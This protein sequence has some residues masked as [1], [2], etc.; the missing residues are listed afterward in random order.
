[1]S[2]ALGNLLQYLE[3]TRPTNTANLSGIAMNSRERVRAALQHRRPDAIPIDFGAT[4]VTGIHVSCVA[5]LRDHYGLHRHPVKVHEPYQM[6]GLIEDDLREAM[7]IDTVGITPRTTMFGF[8]NTA[9]REFRLPWGQEVLV[10]DRFV[11]RED[12]PGDLLIYPEGDRTAPPSGRMPAGGYFFDTI[13]RQEPVDDDHL[14]PLENQE[15]F[16]PLTPEDLAYFT[17]RAKDLAGSTHAVVATFGG[18]AFGDIALVPAPFLKHP[19]GIRDISEWYISTVTRRPYV[20]AIFEHQCEIALENLRSVHDAVGESVDVVFICGTDFGTQTSQFCSPETFDELYAPYY[21]RVN[22]WIHRHTSW[23]T[24]KHSCGAVGPLITRFIDSGFDILNP[25]QCS[26]AGMDPYSLKE[27]Y[28]D[29]LVFWGGVVDTQ[30]T[31]PFGTPEQVRREVRDRCRVFGEGGG[32][33]ANS[34]HNI[35][36][37]TPV[38]NIVAMIET[39]HSV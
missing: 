30:N 29:R 23:K 5:A 11:T 3:S 39:I 8:P 1:M 13:V 17:D 6:L 4:A 10:S 28:G 25:V 26:A 21:R 36:A 22:E 12:P 2:I 9:W 18:M 31:L 33:V 34:V 37:K 15:E 14:N 20:H 7:G 19:R 16:T 32:F 38:E 27:Q 24:F 35:Q